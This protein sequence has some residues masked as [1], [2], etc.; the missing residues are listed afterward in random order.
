M[1]KQFLVLIFIIL[2]VSCDK[3]NK[4]PIKVNDSDV[5]L[6]SSNVSL[7]S[8][9]LLIKANNYFSKYQIEESKKELLIL[10]KK[11]PISDE[12]NEAK[13]L[14]IDA[15]YELIKIKKTDD[16]IR[17]VEE[18]IEKLRIKEATK[19]LRKE[20]DKLENITWY[21]DKTSPRYSNY[22]GFYLYVGDSGY[23]FPNLRLRI[24][25]KGDKWLFIKKYKIYIDDVE[26]RTIETKYGDVKR[27]NGYGGVWEWIDISINNYSN[28]EEIIDDFT[29]LYLI[30]RGKDVKVKYIGSKYHEIKT[31]SN[32]QKKAIKNV[33]EAYRALG[34]ETN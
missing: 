3:V 12:V 28:N 27:D 4:E 17:K 2:F 9:E 29:L 5:S 15:N 30:S 21:T 23:G 16:S 31:L 18:K 11:Y 1:K 8:K 20:V 10:L 24:Q 14:L 13:K 34:G 22:N 32:K 26:Y 6:N 19:S 7:D 33:L 25:Y